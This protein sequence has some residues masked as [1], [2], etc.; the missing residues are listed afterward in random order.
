MTNQLAKNRVQ[1]NCFLWSGGACVHLRSYLIRPLA[2]KF[3]DMRGTDVQ[4]PGL[5]RKHG[6]VTTCGL[7]CPISDRGENKRFALDLVLLICIA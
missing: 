4:E 7:D 3:G 2:K 5:M 1:L 6:L